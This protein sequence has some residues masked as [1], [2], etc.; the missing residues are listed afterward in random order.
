MTLQEI[1]TTMNNPETIQRREQLM[2][3]IEC[4]VDSYETSE[5]TTT[6]LITNLCDAVCCNF[7]DQAAKPSK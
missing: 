2:I 4:I 6:Q 3:D 5:M 1:K 7:P